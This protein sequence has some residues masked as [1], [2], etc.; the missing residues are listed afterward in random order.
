MLIYH[1]CFSALETVYLKEKENQIGFLGVE[2]G[3]S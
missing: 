1:K 3:C 2:E